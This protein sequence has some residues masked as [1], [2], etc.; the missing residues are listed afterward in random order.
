MLTTTIEKRRIVRRNVSYYIPVVEAN[1]TRLAGVMLDISLGGF[2][3][4]SREQ[5]P[6]GSINKFYINLPDDTTLHTSGI[7][8]GRSKWCSPD[9]FDPSTYN[10]GYEFV[11]VSS[12]NAFLFQHLLEKFGSQPGEGRRNDNDNYLWQ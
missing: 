6:Q 4:D 1:T 3:L 5:I 12:D 7:F 10:V 8:I 11:N 2:K 9:Y